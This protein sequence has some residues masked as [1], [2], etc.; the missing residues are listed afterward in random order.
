MKYA[1]HIP[2]ICTRPQQ[3]KTQAGNFTNQPSRFY[4]RWGGFVPRALTLTTL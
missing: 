2:G 1:E 3:T 4:R